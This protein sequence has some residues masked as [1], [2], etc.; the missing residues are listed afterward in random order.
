MKTTI[1]PYPDEPYPNN[2]FKWKSWWVKKCFQP[3]EPLTEGAIKWIHQCW[4]NTLANWPY[5]K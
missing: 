2:E 4:Q 3:G 5:A 1:S